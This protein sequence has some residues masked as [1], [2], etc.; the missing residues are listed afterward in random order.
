M[1]KSLNQGLHNIKP[2]KVPSDF[3]WDL[4]EIELYINIHFHQSYDEWKM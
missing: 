3:L 1:S 4:W 2:R